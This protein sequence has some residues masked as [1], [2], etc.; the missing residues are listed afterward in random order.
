VSDA[1]IPDM[2][3]F[4]VDDACAATEADEAA[5]PYLIATEP[6]DTIMRT[7]TYDLSIS[8]DKYYQVR[9]AWVAVG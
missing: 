8:Y 2:A 4:E 5:L 7:R 9:V 3:D 6:E 1:D